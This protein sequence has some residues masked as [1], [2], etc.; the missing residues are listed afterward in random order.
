MT[1][2][3]ITTAIVDTHNCSVVQQE[4]TIESVS[5][6]ENAE[7]ESVADIA[8]LVNSLKV[9]QMDYTSL[10]FP[11]KNL[12]CSGLTKDIFKPPRTA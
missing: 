8:D 3:V 5:E 4:I 2:F 10:S 6:F 9:V 7:S 11:D 1:F 12:I